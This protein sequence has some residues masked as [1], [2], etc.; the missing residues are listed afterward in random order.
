MQEEETRE[1][2]RRKPKETHAVKARATT[3]LNR[4]SRGS[5]AVAAASPRARHSRSANRFA[6]ER[7]R[8]RAPFHPSST[9]A[10]HHVSSRVSRPTGHAAAPEG[11]TASLK[12]AVVPGHL[13]SP[14]RRVRALFPRSP[15]LSLSLSPKNPA[16]TDRAARGA[17][18][19]RWLDAL[20]GGE[21][22]TH[23]A[24]GLLP[25]WRVQKHECTE[26]KGGGDDRGFSLPQSRR[27][28]GN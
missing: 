14:P 6:R 18:R 4:I 27:A 23:F 15:S 5:T 13:S 3:D 12:R 20:R 17:G 26:R 2:A 19:E 28:G 25:S 7:E 21:G 1:G 11:P 8:E 24:P 9:L 10:R 16:A 22:G